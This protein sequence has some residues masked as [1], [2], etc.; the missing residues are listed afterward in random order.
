M[1][2]CPAAVDAPP[3]TMGDVRV[4]HGRRDVAVTQQFLDRLDV[5]AASGKICCQRCRNVW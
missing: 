4:D 5:V 2:N 1:L 3:A